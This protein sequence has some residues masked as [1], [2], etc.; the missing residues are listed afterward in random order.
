MGKMAVCD[1]CGK[2]FDIDLCEMMYDQKYA[3]QYM[4]ESFDAPVCM[5]CAIQYT[6]R[7]LA[8]DLTQGCE[9]TW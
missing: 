9:D 8:T 5:G 7:G 4:Y 3:P 1:L 2:T 6:E